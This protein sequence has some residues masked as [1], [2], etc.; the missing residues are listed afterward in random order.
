MPRYD[1]LETVIE[2]GI[3]VQTLVDHLVAAGQNVHLSNPALMQELVEKLPGTMRME[4]AVYKSRLPVATLQSFGDFMSRMVATASEVSY[5]LPT[6]DRSGK[7]DR[8]KPKSKGAVHA[9][10]AE[11]STIST[12]ST[13][14]VKTGKSVKPCLCCSREGHRL[15]D[16]SRF[17]SLNADDRWKLAEQKGLCRTCLNNHG[18]WPCRS[19]KG[20]E[21]EGCRHKHHTLLHGTALSSQSTGMS[22]SHLS[23]GQFCM[24]R[25]VPVVLHG[26]GKDMLIFAFIDEGSSETLIEEAVAKQLEVTGPIEP[27]TLHWTGSVSREESNSQ[28]IQLQIAAKSSAVCHD[29]HNVR[30]VSCLLLPSQTLRYG[31]IVQRFP[32][33]RGLPVEDYTNVQPKLLIGLNNLGLC[34]P[35]KMREGGPHD[36]VAVKCHLGWSIY[37]GEPANSRYS[38]A[39]N[40]H[41][42]APADP[43]KLLNEQLRD[44]FA[45]ES[46]MVSPGIQTD[47]EDDKRAR[48]LLESSTRRIG[49][50]FETGLLWRTDAVDFPDSYSI[51]LRRLQSL[52]RKL[53]QNPNLGDRVIQQIRDYERKGYA[54]RA[55]EEDLACSDTSRIWYLP[56]GIVIN[57]KKPNKLRLIWDAAAKVGD[58]SFNSKL[59]KGPDLL[60]PLLAVLSRFRQFPVAV[61][62]DIREM[63]HQIKIRKEDQQSQR[64]LWREHPS[65]SPLVYIMEVATFGSTCSPASAQFVKN[66]NATEY[67]DQFPRAA[68]AIHD[69][70]YVDDYLDSFQTIEDAIQ[71]VQE[72]QSVRA[73][74]GFEIRNILS[75]STEVIQRID[76]RPS[77]NSKDLAL[78]R[79]DSTESVLGM[80]WLPKEDAFTY[81]F[82]LR[83]DIQQVLKEDHV[84]TKREVLKVVMS[85][86]DPLG[87]LSFFLVH[88]KILI[89]D[90]WISKIGWDDP[91][92]ESCFARWKQWIA[93]FDQLSS[94]RIP[95]CYFRAPYPS[96]FGQLQLHIFVDASESAYSCVA[97]FRLPVGDQIQVSMV[98]AKTK[99]APIN[100]ISIP[101]LELKAAVLGTRLS[102]SI[103]Q[104]HTV[105]IANVFFW[106][107]SKT[108]L[109][110]IQSEHRRYHK[111]VA[112]RVGEILLS[113]DVK[114]WR[115]VPSKINPADEA[116]KWKT[117]PNLN[118]DGPWFRGPNFLKQQETS[119]PEQL[120][121]CTTQDELRSVHLH[122]VQ[123]SVVDPARFGRIVPQPIP[124][125]E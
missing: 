3:A 110:W 35:R 23:I 53:R 5:E 106:S 109:A 16:C 13:S 94:L 11:S 96:D 66:L 26:K 52:E 78:T 32:H 72:V 76:E 20:C 118:S 90:T 64:F 43:D 33:L 67:A 115:W 47:S 34:L 92:T 38:V 99:V 93:L 48:I 89:Q 28:R 37:G 18:K 68:A 113:T 84:P 9:H 65:D 49:N 36:P 91:V 14:V 63:F 105:P 39:V 42:A 7:I 55:T 83:S 24:F 56:L 121:T 6:L 97:Y 98:A 12:P 10:S 2:F 41:T 59:L 125:C 80:Q 71:V 17:K 60:T 45:I 58:V 103:K 46:C 95:R 70:H 1:R 88:G 15:V 75:N 108:V 51:A 86:F 81:T 73:M 112:V 27:L 54:R 124:P 25:I 31:E 122:H 120:Q 69:N 44:Y 87:C 21:V 61:T 102:E 82:A 111:F 50:R 119:W 114:N 57:P 30:T 100:T 107:D 4:W 74:G 79:G 104:Y 19:W 85:L 116:T 117:G 40:F 29:L 77:E 62:G 8:T 123:C 22:A 101:R